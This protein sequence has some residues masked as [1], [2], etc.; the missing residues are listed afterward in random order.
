MPLLTSIFDDLYILKSYSVSFK[1]SFIER[2]IQNLNPLIQ[3]I[4]IKDPNFTKVISKIV[5]DCVTPLE[6]QIKLHSYV[7]HLLS[8][9]SSYSFYWFSSKIVLLIGLCS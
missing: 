9:E 3:G 6:I 7:K 1:V 8:L 5:S 4:L 2:E